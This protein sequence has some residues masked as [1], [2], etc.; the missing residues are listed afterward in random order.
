VGGSV[1]PRISALLSRAAT[2]RGDQRRSSPRAADDWYKILASADGD[3]AEIWLYTEIDG[4]WGITAEEFVGEL[5]NITASTIKL[6]V[7]CRGGDVFDGLAIYQALLSHP[8]R[9]EV[10]ID[11]L[12]ASA[13][14]YIVQ[15][16]DH[17]TIGPSAMVMIHDAW[18]GCCGNAGDMRSMAD[19]LDKISVDIADL[20]V[21]H[22]GGTSDEWRERMLVDGGRGTWYTGAEAVEAGLADEVL[23]LGKRRRCDDEDGP[24]EGDDPLEARVAAAQR[25]AADAIRAEAD[26]PEPSAPPAPDLQAGGADTP[27]D[28]QQP[29]AS[30]QGPDE[31]EPQDETWGALTA[32]LIN[33]DPWASLTK[34]LL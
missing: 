16:G 1:D 10:Q 26:D 33:V 28:D 27:D 18:G 4:W 34:G 8:A 13:A 32:G 11:G 6:R 7:N 17:V 22:A 2:L 23:D 24:D 3:T 30:D 21:R 19:L 25:A 5:R 29:E 15:A 31:S 14:S 12:A 20:Y 9:V